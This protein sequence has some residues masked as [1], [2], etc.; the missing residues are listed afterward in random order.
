MKTISRARASPG[1]SR[2][3][4]QFDH[5]NPNIDYTADEVHEFTTES[6]SYLKE[7]LNLT[8]TQTLLKDPIGRA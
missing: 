5:V 1:R 4:S 2:I 8:E 6:M 3:S 7:Y